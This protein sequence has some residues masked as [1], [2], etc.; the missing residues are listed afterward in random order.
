MPRLSVNMNQ[1][2]AD[3]LALLRRNHDVTVTEAVRRAVSVAVYL[4]RAARDGHTISVY[5]PKKRA[6]T[7]VVFL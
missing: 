1:E 6:T 2:T 5:D 4:E 3:A 7:G